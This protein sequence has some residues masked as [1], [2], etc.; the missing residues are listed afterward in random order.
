MEILKI[1]FIKMKIIVITVQIKM[2]C[3]NNDTKNSKNEKHVLESCQ[4]LI[5]R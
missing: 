2:D 1:E 4:N 3:I 5:Q